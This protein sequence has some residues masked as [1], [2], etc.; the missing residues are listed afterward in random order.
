VEV[1]MLIFQ[2]EGCYRITEDLEAKKRDII[3]QLVKNH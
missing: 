1:G 2:D 3:K